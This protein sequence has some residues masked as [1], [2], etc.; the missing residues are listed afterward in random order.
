MVFID[1]DF[2][3][4]NNSKFPVNYELPL[5]I[6]K[7]S[8]LQA[9]SFPS[10]EN[11]DSCLADDRDLVESLFEDYC[12]KGYPFLIIISEKPMST[13]IPP[14]FTVYKK[15]EILWRNDQGAQKTI[16]FKEAMKEIAKFNTFTWVEFSRYL[17]TK[18]NIGGRMLYVDEK[19]QVI[20]IQQGTVPSQLINNL[21]FPVYAGK[22]SNLK[23]SQKEYS[24][25]ANCLLNLG[26][27]HVI[28]VETVELLL[29]ILYSHKEGFRELNKISP[30]PTFEFAFINNRLLV[31]IDIDWPAQWIDKER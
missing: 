22:I 9:L 1:E 29:E 25:N 12:N 28:P 7:R 18:R 14:L 30:K 23:F 2:L 20:E 10:N 27:K 21:E 24:Q 19:E 16:I 8:L 13:L 5:R 3:L 26:Y 11:M 17:W 6:Q 15:N 31:S 4:K